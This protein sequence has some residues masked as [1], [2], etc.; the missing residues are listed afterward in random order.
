MPKVMMPVWSDFDALVCKG[1]EQLIICTPYYSENGLN[2]LLSNVAENVSIDLITKI[3]PSDWANGASDPEALV[4]FI[5]RTNEKKV[6]V[7]LFIQ[8]K[9]HAKIYVADTKV[10]ILGSS[11]L[12]DGGFEKNL[13]VIVSFPA[14]RVKDVIDFIEGQIKNEAV[15]LNSKQLDKWVNKYKGAVNRV[16]KVSDMRQASKLA[17]AQKKLDKMLGYG[18]RGSRKIKIKPREM[19]HFVRW[20]NEHKGLPGAAVLSD[21]YYNVDGLNLQGHFKQSFYSTIRFL[22]ENQ[23]IV[24]ILTDEIKGLKKGDVYQLSDEVSKNWIKHVDDHATDADDGY[25]YAILRGILPPNLGGT[26]M[27]GGGGSSTLKRMLPLVAEYLKEK[28]R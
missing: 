15:A 7:R 1:K 21:R 13:E 8:Q 16:R 24:K 3:S 17:A 14:K 28:K 22:I 5:K 9:L 11:N 26:R 10:A 2:H 20:L 12:S 4:A 25:D 18:K 19:Q 23:A 6:C 27:G